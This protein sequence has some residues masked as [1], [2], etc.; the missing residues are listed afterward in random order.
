MVIQ[1]K[2]EQVINRQLIRPDFLL[3]ENILQVEAL[4]NVLNYGME[5]QENLLEI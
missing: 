5:K 1:F 4:I 3:M 2:D